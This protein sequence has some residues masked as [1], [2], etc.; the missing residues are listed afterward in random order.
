M[1]LFSVVTG[2]NAT[3]HADSFVYNRSQ[4]VN[5]GGVVLVS[6]SDAHLVNNIIAL[7]QAGGSVGAGVYV[8]T[9]HPSLSIRRMPAMK[10]AMGRQL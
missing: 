8:T 2:S 10:A 6:G 5:G 9:H 4:F 1:G 3:V 7:N